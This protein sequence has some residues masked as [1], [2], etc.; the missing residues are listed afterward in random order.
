MDIVSLPIMLFDERKLTPSFGYVFDAK[1]LDPHESIVSILW[2]L[3]R[4]NRLSGHLITAQL[5][6][7]SIDPYEGVAASRSEV[8]MR[9]LRQALRLPLNIVRASLLP[10]ALQRI[11]SPYFRYCRKCLYRGYHGVVHQLET[12]KR[13]PVHGCDLLEEACRYCDSRTP[14]RLNAYLLD[15]PYRCGNCRSLYSS[16]VPSLLNKPALSKKA[17][18]AITRLRLNHCSYF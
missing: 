10:D 11:G 6:R 16:R 17:R 15:G 5:S 7:S 1:W 18:T 13:C 4:M 3:A 9:R 8:D 14:Y 2:K 12:V